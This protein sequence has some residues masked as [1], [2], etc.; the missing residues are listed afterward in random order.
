MR[1]SCAGP[2][3]R[4][5]AVPQLCVAH[6]LHGPLGH[7]RGVAGR[8][9][10]DVSWQALWSR[11]GAGSVFYLCGLSVETKLSRALHKLTRVDGATA[12]LVPCRDDLRDR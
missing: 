12:V 6:G 8:C 11:Y 2:E 4:R 10:L 9:E 5:R 3:H 7:G 1:R